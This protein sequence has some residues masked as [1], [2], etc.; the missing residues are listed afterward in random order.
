MGFEHWIMDHF[1]WV[2]GASLLLLVAGH[3]AVIWLIR[4]GKP[5]ED[6]PS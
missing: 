2:I 5:K 6:Q 4:Q 3:F 1:W